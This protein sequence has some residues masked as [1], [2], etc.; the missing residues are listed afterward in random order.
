M[1][2]KKAMVEFLAQFPKEIIDNVDIETPDSIGMPYVLHIS[3][4]GKIKEFVPQLS[5]RTAKKEDRIVPRISTAVSLVACILGYQT[6][7]LDFDGN[8]DYYDNFKGGWY[9]YAFDFNLALQAKK[10][11]LYDVIKTDEIWLVPY[12][13]DLWI[14]KPQIIAKFF[15]ESVAVRW[16]KEER[17]SH[18]KVVLENMSERDVLINSETRVSKGYWTFEL[19][20]IKMSSSVK[21]VKVTNLTQIDQKRYNELKRIN[22]SLLSM[23]EPLSLP[24][25]KW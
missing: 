8:R 14:Y 9:I 20:N 11:I 21:S 3:T 5:R 10:K 22:A 17:I 1:E 15:L 7:E 12:R 6:L 25:L 24:S 16:E 23:D 4:D 19:E 2:D 13:Q 18:F